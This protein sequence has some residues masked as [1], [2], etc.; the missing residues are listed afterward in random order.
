[1]DHNCNDENCTHESHEEMV[2]EEAQFEELVENNAVVLDALIDL[3]IEKNVISEDMLTAKI[4][5]ISLEESESEDEDED[6][7]DEEDVED[8]SDKE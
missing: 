3:L 5:Q 7:D 4:E 2:E 8:D 1:M 6:E